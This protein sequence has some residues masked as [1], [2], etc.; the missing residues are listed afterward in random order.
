MNAHLGTARSL[1]C[2]AGL[3]AATIAFALA[4][5][6]AK[7][8]P[9]PLASASGKTTTAAQF[10]PTRELSSV[11]FEGISMVPLTM[12]MSILERVQREGVRRFACASLENVRAAPTP[13]ATR[14]RN[15]ALLHETWT[16]RQCGQDI[17]YLVKVEYQDNGWTRFWITPRAA[18]A[19]R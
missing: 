4:G 9:S 13:D 17:A 8:L 5:A 7:N 15:D 6:N 10:T 19:G 14:G 18:P 2:F 1:R 11:L 16:V 3:A 12:R